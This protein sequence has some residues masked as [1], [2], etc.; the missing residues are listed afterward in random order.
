MPKRR[1]HHT[2]IRSSGFSTC[3]RPM[4]MSL[5]SISALER[6]VWVERDTILS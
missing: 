5:L 1:V 2:L 6:L 3:F 4:R